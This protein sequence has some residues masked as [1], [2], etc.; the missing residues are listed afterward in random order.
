MLAV[1]HVLGQLL[2]IFGV[3]FLLPT[4][5]SLIYRD[6][7]WWHFVLAGLISSGVGLLIW[8]STRR[9]KRELKSRDGFLLVTLAWVLVAGA[10]TIPLLLTIPGLSFTDAYFETTSGLTT[11][12]ATILTG[13]DG[14]PP[15]INLWR[16]ALHWFGGMGIIVL[17]LAIL[18]LLGVGG[19]QIYKAEA[20]GPVKDTRLTP[21]ITE[22]AKVLWFTYT[23][24]T[25]ACII[26][27]KLCGI[28]WLDAICHAFSVMALG[29]FSTYDAS[30]AHFNSPAVE[31][32]LMAF[33]L[34]AAMN[35]GRHF[36]A[37][38]RLSLAP[39]VADPE[40]GP[41]LRVIAVSILLLAG[42][43]AAGG[44]Y[45]NF[46]TTLRH[47]AFAVISMGTTTG[48]VTEDWEKWPPFAGYWLLLLTGI[49]CNTGSTGG[50]IKMFRTL[51][52]W[53]QALR[54][55]RLMVH[56]QAVEPIRIGGQVV[57]N[58]I[59]YAVL[60]F[61][62][63]Y[64]M[65][66]VTLTLTLLLSGLDFSSS[67]SAVISSINNTGPGLNRVGPSTNYGS[68]SDFQTWVCTLAMLLGRLEIFSVLVLFTPTFW[69]K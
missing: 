67:M 68:L 25:S 17:A 18:P 4:A 32:V 14:L 21:R 24:I 12:G 55:M 28:S 57:P 52:L 64:F 43:T 3:T 46:G 53:R 6:D 37:L 16:C 56:P 50:G 23:G 33:M 58:R 54:E 49:L 34:I 10:A 60:A 2:S 1:V 30:I 48:F 61:I 42:I 69:R 15:A 20:P 13:I 62:F 40:I 26:A 59:V 29:G 66:V 41:M 31:L 27:L 5:A 19:M 47:A 38:R 7:T 44:T 36:L 9:F 63:L 11:S 45:S 22:T 8:A 65:T 35:F 39:Y 51:L